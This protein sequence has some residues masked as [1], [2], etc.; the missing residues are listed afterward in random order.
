[1][2]SPR[3]IAELS[4]MEPVKSKSLSVDNSITWSNSLANTSKSTTNKNLG[5]FTSTSL[6]TAFAS[7]NGNG[8]NYMLINPAIYDEDT[9]EEQLE[10][11]SYHLPSSLALS[12]PGGSSIF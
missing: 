8:F 12:V 11:S 5:G 2:I 7:S 1:M 6:N 3:N 4:P 10:E 9:I